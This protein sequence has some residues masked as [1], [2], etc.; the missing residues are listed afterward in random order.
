MD[1][2]T[3]LMVRNRL[4]DLPLQDEQGN[5]KQLPE[6]AINYILSVTAWAMSRALVGV[7]EDFN[8]DTEDIEEI[9]RRIV[10]LQSYKTG[11]D[12]E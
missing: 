12:N 6:N 2:F 3:A 1:E 8:L 9:N 7:G 5:P 10:E 4:E 11:S